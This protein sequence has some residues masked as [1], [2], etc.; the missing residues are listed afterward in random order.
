MDSNEIDKLLRHH[1]MTRRY[2]IGCFGSDQIPTSSVNYPHCMVVNTDRAGM[3]G[4]H[5]IAVFVVDAQRAEYYDSF[6]QWPPVENIDNYL[7]H[8]KYIENNH[9]AFQSQ[10]SGSCGRHAI[11]FLIRRCSGM[12]FS[13]IMH[14]L[15]QCKSTPDS[16]V[17]A[18]VRR[19]F[20]G[21]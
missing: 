4:E 19:Y 12:R 2:Y 17:C 6:G 3:I 14:H 10:Y 20:S 8:F 16:I 15:K 5:W 18:Y 13:E 9:H 11:Y 1:Q 21:I 7:A